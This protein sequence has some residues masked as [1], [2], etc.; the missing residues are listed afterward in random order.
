MFLNSPLVQ[1]DLASTFAS[2]LAS[3]RLVTAAAEVGPL[4]KMHV[5]HPGAASG[6]EHHELTQPHGH[7]AKVTVTCTDFS[8]D[9]VQVEQVADLDDFLARHR[10]EWAVVRWVN[11]DGL[12]DM[13]VVRA[14]AVK[15][16]LHP[17]LVEDVVHVG[18]RP[19]AEDYP[20]T[21]EHLAR[22]FIIARMLEMSDGQV[23]NEQIS[24]VLGR[25]TLLTFQERQGDVWDSIRQ[26]IGAKGSRVRQ[27]DVSFLFYSLLDAII[28]Q[29]FP[30]LDFYSE[31][32]E[33]L[34]D[35][36][37][38]TRTGD[39]IRH[40]HAARRELLTVRRCVWPMRE[41][42]NSLQREAHE[43]M[44]EVTRTYLRDLYDNCVQIIDLV[45]TYREFA[46]GLTD[47]HMSAY[48]SA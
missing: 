41:V 23:R 28:D 27:N 35:Q 13:N 30:I 8:P 48:R 15:Y 44:S 12:S 25:N 9:C 17:L 43:C 36:A 1:S 29:Y 26:R 32:L 33:V 34:E 47:I 46:T 24:F 42:I 22:L 7:S 19:K 37:L 40:I 31:Q 16:D 21:G 45:E 5:I 4:P 10:P 11:I 2:G 39:T 14:F 18:Q 3:S 6:I 20:N 38:T